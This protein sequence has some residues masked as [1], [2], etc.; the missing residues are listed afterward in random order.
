MTWQSIRLELDRTPDFPNGSAGRAYLLRLPLLADGAIDEAAMSRSPEQA[1]MR[2]LWSN[3]PDIGGYV[4]PRGH[5]WACVSVIRDKPSTVAEFDAAQIRVGDRL[6]V[7]EAKAGLLPFRIV[8]MRP[9]SARRQK[10]S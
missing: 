2:R 8:G 7:D 9:L 3:E 5:R 10:P 1:T 4:R 6:L